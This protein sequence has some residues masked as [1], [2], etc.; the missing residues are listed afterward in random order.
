FIWANG[1]NVVQEVAAAPS[2]GESKDDFRERLILPLDT[3]QSIVR[4]L[5]Y[6]QSLM[7]HSLE[8]RVRTCIYLFPGARKPEKRVERKTA[9]R[10]APIMGFLQRSRTERGLRWVKCPEMPIACEAVFLRR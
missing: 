8:P 6:R 1:P 2:L 5:R 3:R 10:N 4:L 9:L 7:S